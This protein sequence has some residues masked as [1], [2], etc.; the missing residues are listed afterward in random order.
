M[1]VDLRL[2]GV[3]MM[4]GA[5]RQETVE[6]GVEEEGVEEEEVRHRLERARAAGAGLLR[7]R[8]VRACGFATAW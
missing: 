3:Q 5:V 6:V 1:A 8:V 2:I 7:C 4:T